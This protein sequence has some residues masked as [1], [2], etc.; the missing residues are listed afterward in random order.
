MP[1]AAAPA[2]AGPAVCAADCG[3]AA[4]ADGLHPAEGLFDPLNRDRCDRLLITIVRLLAQHPHFTSNSLS[5]ACA[6]P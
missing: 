3:C 2:P 6:V 5:L 1:V 4:A